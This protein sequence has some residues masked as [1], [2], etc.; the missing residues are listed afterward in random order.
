[1]LDHGF[2]AVRGLDVASNEEAGNGMDWASLDHNSLVKPQSQ[3][4]AAAHKPTRLAVRLPVVFIGARIGRR[5]VP[6]VLP[7]PMD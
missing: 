2:I 5:S 4:G 1:M 7:A 6:C 3:R